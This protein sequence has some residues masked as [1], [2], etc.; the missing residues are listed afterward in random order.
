MNHEIK[1][2]KTPREVVAQA[3]DYASW[4]EKLA[5]EDIAAIYRR[6][7]P[8]RSLDADFLERFGR[9]LD[10]ETLNDSHEI[11]VVAG[12]LDASSERIVAYLNERSIPINVLCFQVFAHGNDQILSRAWLHDPVEVQGIGTTTS[13][14]P[15]E[16]WNGEFYCSFGHDECRSWEEAVQ[17]GFICGGGGTWFSGTLRL[18]NPGDR[19]WV[20]VPKT[21]YVGVGRVT[22]V[23]QP[24]STF[25]VPTPKGDK[26]VLEVATR[27]TYHREFVDDLDKCEWFVPIQWL[28]TRP[29]SQAVHETG[30][31]GLQHTVCRPASAKWR[32]TVERLKQV[33]TRFDG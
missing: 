13:K 10:E 17:F 15:S 28:E 20:N 9:T 27:A 6:F 33:F 8:G 18:L 5:G 4:V 23:A 24:A 25:M 30:F 29:L 22:G 14:G 3:L 26:P 12:S 31:F 11:V 21:G 32:T 19:V 2:D 1:R 7:K 16:P